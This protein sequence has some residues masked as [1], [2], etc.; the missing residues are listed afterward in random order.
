MSRARPLA[1]VV[2]AAS[3]VVP[4]AAFAQARTLGSPL[5]RAP[6]LH[7]CETE[8]T[9][10]ANSSNGDYE[11]LPSGDPDCTWFQGGVVGAFNYSDPRTGSVP[12][13][14]TITTVS[15][16]SGPNPSPLRFV[17]VRQFEQSAGGFC[18]AFVPGRETGLVQ[19]RPN[20]ISTFTIN[21]PV[22]R[23]VDTQR[24][25]ITADYIGVSGVT[26]GGLLPIADTGDNNT[27]SGY[28]AGSPVAGFLYPRLGQ[29]PGD[30]GGGRNEKGI[31]NVEVLLR[32]TW[33]P[34]PGTGRDG[35]APLMGRPAFGPRI[36]VV[37]PN[38]TPVAAKA[39]RGSTLSFTVNERSTATIRIQKPRKGR[40]S[41]GKCRKPTR[42]NRKGKRCKRWVK[43]AATL[44]RK[45]VGPGKVSIKFTG[46]IRGKA[47]KRGRYRASIT[48][49][50][51]AKNK[52]KPRNAT[53][54]IVKR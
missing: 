25:I 47:L 9:F 38:N 28:T 2:V 5:T 34:A 3:L 4:A 39:K 11:A 33:V 21:M 29:V 26:G 14:G 46:R 45:N 52:A 37:G 12:S 40:R 7:G 8:P 50:D 49:T 17:V 23:N 36:F 48:L 54:R 35:A 10:T 15:V 18:C 53:F 44:T 27:L 41:E 6:N 1:C 24:G 32:W 42:K 31:P 16:R 20:A 22:E 13:D 19:P 51:A 43:A 30:T